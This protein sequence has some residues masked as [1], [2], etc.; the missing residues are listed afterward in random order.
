[1]TARSCQVPPRWYT[2]LYAEKKTI[3]EIFSTRFDFFYP[4]APYNSILP[5]ESYIYNLQCT[6]Y[7]F[8]CLFR[9][10]V[11][12]CLQ[13]YRFPS[14]K[15]YPR[16]FTGAVYYKLSHAAPEQFNPSIF[17]CPAPC[18]IPHP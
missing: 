13:P 4:F 18:R 17:P 5:T 11:S 7:N 9:I 12:V 14:Q 10:H 8:G 2:A 16:S 1:M 15:Q 6:I 3:V